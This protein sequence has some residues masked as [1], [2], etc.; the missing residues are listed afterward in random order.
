MLQL[1]E[2]KEELQRQAVARGVRFFGVADLTP[3]M[4]FIVGQGGS[5]LS[6]YKYC[7]TLGYPLSTGYVEAL[8]YQDSRAALTTYNYLHHHVDLWLDL[9]NVLLSRYIEDAGYRALPAPTDEMMDHDRALSLLALKT[10]FRLA[11]LGWIGKN[12]LI[13]TPEIGPRLRLGAI[14]TDAPLPLSST[15]PM[16]DRCG[17]CSVCVD[18][19]PVGALAGKS[20]DPS[21]SRKERLDLRKCVAYRRE[22]EKEQGAFVCGLC[23]YSCPYGTKRRA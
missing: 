21:E 4:D 2:L 3:A 9:T 1:Q 6:E 17:E 16:E 15:M 5:F 20:F 13:I 19:C 14:L 11:G 22:R 23:M 12:N 18:A 10:P 7:I 8:R